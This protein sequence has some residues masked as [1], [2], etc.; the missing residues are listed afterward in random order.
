MTL[1]NSRGVKLLADENIPLESIRILKSQGID[2][3]SVVEHKTGMSD[4]SVLEPSW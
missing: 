3:T 4:K 2:V 1:G